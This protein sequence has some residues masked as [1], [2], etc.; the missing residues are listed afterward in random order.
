VISGIRLT[1]G[2]GV[3]EMNIQVIDVITIVDL[4]NASI[5]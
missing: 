1:E 2:E 3:D 4:M 5:N